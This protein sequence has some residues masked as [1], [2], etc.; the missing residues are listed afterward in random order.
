[1]AYSPTASPTAN[2]L[3]FHRL[4]RDYDIWR[5][6]TD[7]GMEPLIVSSLVDAN[8]QFSPD[9][10]RIAFES[11]RSGEAM[12]I[13]VVQADGSKPVQLTNRV[14]R[15]QGTPHWSPDGRWIAFDSQGRDG[16]W[17]VYA[18][19]AMGGSPRRITSEPSD[20]STPVWSHEGKWIYF[21]SDR[22]GSFEFWRVPFAGGQPEQVTTRG[23]YTAYESA[24]GETLF[25]T[26][27]GS[28]ALFSRRLSGGEER[29]V[30]P[31]I[32][33]KSFVPVA[34]GIYYIGRR[35]DAGYYSLDFFQFS[36]AVSRL[37]VKI[38]G[39]VSS[40]LSVSPDGKTILFTKSVSVAADLMMIENF[41]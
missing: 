22:S 1:M 10:T 8:P 29:Q 33:N 41:Q 24:D 40:G 35:S 9:G 39:G 14:G 25:Y 36:S 27:A 13:W 19:E 4:L 20:D 17:D 7:G 6:R 23:G 5:H 12:E 16:H 3:I 15:Y 30:L 32:Y 11:S 21:R 34:D 26:K 2:R 31:Y 28:G 38:E 37:V 18:I